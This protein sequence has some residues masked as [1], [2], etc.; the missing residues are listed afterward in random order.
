MSPALLGGL[1]IAFAL[2]AVLRRP[3]EE[4][5]RDWA[6]I[7]RHATKIA[8]HRQRLAELEKERLMTEWRRR[9]PEPEARSKPSSVVNLNAD[10]HWRG[11]R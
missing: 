5:S 2:L 6:W 10:R 9:W 8:R 1:A 7:R 4:L 11:P 3:Y